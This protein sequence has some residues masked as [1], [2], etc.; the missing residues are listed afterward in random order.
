M[1]NQVLF[2]VAFIGEHLFTSIAKL[3]SGLGTE[4]EMGVSLLGLPSSVAG[5]KLTSGWYYI[6]FYPESL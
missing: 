5:V 4:D 2:K 3:V 1:V 6:K